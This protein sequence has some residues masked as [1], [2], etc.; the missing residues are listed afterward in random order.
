VVV[1]DELDALAP[2]REKAHGDQEQRIVATFLT[3]MDGLKSLKGVVIIG[4]T[5]RINAIDSALRRAGRFEYEIHVGVPDTAGRNEIL[6]IHTRRMPLAGDINLESLA[7][8]TVGFVGADIA[9]LC[10]MAAYNALRRA[11]PP[12]A[13]GKGKA[14]SYDTL[15]V[16]QMD[17]D[18]AVKNIAP[19]AMK[20]FF[21]E[22]PKV[23]WED[24]GGLEDVKRLLVENISYA[25][26]K[27]DV[28]DKIGVK[29]ARGIL[30]YGAPGTG[31]T[32][33]AKAVAT[34]CGANFIS[35]KGPEIRSKWF[36]ESEERIR[37]IFSKAREVTPCVIFF[38][39]IDAAVPARGKDTSGLTDTIVNQ[40]LSEMDGIE[41]ADGI[42][43][44]G[45]TNRLEL[46]DPAVLRPGRFDYQI[47]IPLPDPKARKAIFDINLKGKPLTQSLDVD[48]LVKLTNGL[49]GAEI[50]EICREGIWEALRDGE[51]T[52][53]KVKIT[54]N[55]I[56]SAIGNIKKNKDKFK[57]KVIGFK[58]PEIEKE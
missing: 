23:S 33:L 15:T 54:K 22:I 28:F 58:Q 11:F 12:E 44:I 57:P 51:F 53:E 37:F 42:F 7:Q 52:A 27:R 20:E 55:H 5:N 9:A 8:R 2:R 19:S 56:N 21:V 49:S 6:K 1:I 17:F 35:V 45:A 29:T 47:E 41:N 26:T 14:I 48:E 50:A 3:Q 36:G 32:L 13:F 31:K 46:I 43:V 4:T 16:A 34:Q 10:R 25:I 30:L 38:D 40:I 24:I 39:E 18:N